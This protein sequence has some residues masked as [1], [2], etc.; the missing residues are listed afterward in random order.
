MVERC[1]IRKLQLLAHQYLIS[2]KVEFHIGDREPASPQRFKQFRKLGLVP[3]KLLHAVDSD[4]GWT[5]KK[6]PSDYF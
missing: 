3:V 1:R 6:S 5:H 2:S 4:Y